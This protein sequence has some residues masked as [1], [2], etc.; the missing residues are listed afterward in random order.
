MSLYLIRTGFRVFTIRT[1]SLFTYSRFSRCRPRVNT[2][3]W[4]PTPPPLPPS[5]TPLSSCYSFF[6]TSKF[7]LPFYP[8]LLFFLFVFSYLPL[9]PLSSFLFSFVEQY[10]VRSST[11]LILLFLSTSP[12]FLLFD[13]SKIPKPHSHH[14]GGF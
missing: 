3:I 5:F 11:F 12:F 1:V 10:W 6:L 9:L 4:I 2:I 7:F 14:V 8:S 13:F